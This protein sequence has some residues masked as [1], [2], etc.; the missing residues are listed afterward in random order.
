MG[1]AIK[2]SR[3]VNGIDLLKQLLAFSKN[4]AGHASCALLNR[5]LAASPSPKFIVARKTL[6]DVLE[7]ADQETAHSYFLAWLL[8]CHGPLTGN[9]LLRSLFKVAAPWRPW[10]GPPKRVEAE[11]DIGCERPDI[12]AFWEGFTLI[13]EYK[14]DSPET[15]KQV[16]RYLTRFQIV[17]REAGALLYLTKYGLPPQSVATGDPRVRPLS[18]E[19]VIRLIDVGLEAGVEPAERGRVLVREFRNCMA[20]AMKR[21]FTMGKPTF[22]DSTR[23]M[24]ERHKEFNALRDLASEESKDFI[25]WVIREAEK[26]LGPVLGEDIVCHNAEEVRTQTEYIYRRPAWMLGGVEIGIGFGTEY[27]DG[28]TLPEVDLWLGVILPYPDRDEDEPLR[29]SLSKAL[30]SSLG[31]KWPLKGVPA[32]EAE[33]P[34]YQT[35]KFTS[36]DGASDPYIWAEALLG[37]LVKL[38]TAF[39]PHLDEFIASAP[40]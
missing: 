18:Y 32:S 10:P 29:K 16:S 39:A 21:S 19:E 20:H 25:H 24:F 31:N 11:V 33:W 34:V 5:L 17:T 28:R 4:G 6:F 13:I 30:A 37:N 12:V 15:F 35:V 8:D 3:A 40:L 36:T 22:S 38:A 7:V 27:M 9:W 14:I 26:R 2:N 1:S 23:L